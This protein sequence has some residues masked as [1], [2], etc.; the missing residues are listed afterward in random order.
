MSEI[1]YGRHYRRYHAD[2]AEHRRWQVEFNRRLLHSHL[3]DL[4]ALPAL[5]IGCGMGFAL[6]YLAEEG[7]ELVE[8]IDLDASQVETCQTQGLAAFQVV[9]AAEY[10]AARK[11]HYGLVLA[12]DVIEHMSQ[13]EQLALTRAVYGALVPGGRLICSVPNANSTVATRAR[14]NDFT[15]QSSFTESSLDFLLYNGDFRKI[16]ISGYEFMVHPHRS[17]ARHKDFQRFRHYVK[18]QVQAYVVWYLFRLVRA[19]RRIEMIAELDYAEGSRVPL[20]HN[21]LG[22][23]TK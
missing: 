5:E 3:P 10:V 9:D 12:M 22:V 18:H 19:W 13:Q 17:G 21:L 11:D 8:G 14:Y 2:T 1:D 6:Q 7:F 16:E 20:S 23:A 4:R 15:H